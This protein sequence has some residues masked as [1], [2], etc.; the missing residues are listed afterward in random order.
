MRDAVKATLFSFTEHKIEV[1]IP[2]NI[3]QISLADPDEL[4]DCDDE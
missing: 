2:T 3:F 4:S 1:Y